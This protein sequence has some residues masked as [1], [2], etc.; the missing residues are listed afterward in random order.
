MRRAPSPARSDLVAALDAMRRII[1]VLRRTSLPA[2][3]SLGVGAAQLFVLHQLA[4]APAGSINELATR[5]Y[6]D[7]SSVSVVVRRLVEQG[8]VARRPAAEDARRRELRLTTPG[9]RLMERA[10]TPPQVRLIAGLAVLRPRELATLRR[11]LDRVVDGMGASGE[12][13]TM[14]F[15]ER[16]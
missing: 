2:E 12:P 8:L 11:L 7:Q 9:R 1:R 14:L 15:T 3:R 6:T 16:S 13:P 4:E 5:T 10:P